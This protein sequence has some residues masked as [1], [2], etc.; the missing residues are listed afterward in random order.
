MNSRWFNISVF[1]LWLT[2][3][4]WL[5]IVKIMPS[6][7]VGDPPD[8]VATLSAQAEEETVGYEVHWEED[9][10]GH[11]LI[12]ADRMESGATLID[13]QVHFD[14]LPIRRIFPEALLELLGLNSTVP[15]EIELAARN[16]ALFQAGGGLQRFESTV[17]LDPT[18]SVVKIEGFVAGE[19]LILTI[20]SGGV[21]YET[22][23]PLPQRAMISDGLMPQT[24]MLGLSEGRRWTV[25]VYS[26]LR[27]RTS[28]M[29][30]MQAEVVGRDFITW[31][32]RVE[33]VWLVVYRGDPGSSL[34]RAGKEHAWLW[35]RD[36]GVVLQHRI[37][38]LDGSLTFLRMPEDQ[39]RDLEQS[40]GRQS[41]DFL[42]SDEVAPFIH[43]TSEWVSPD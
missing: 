29:E 14:R 41:R 27:P 3:M 35:V 25:E 7:M 10:I 39:S 42:N 6:L 28:P 20:R 15:D 2:T 11:A 24:R 1:A 13:G 26:P 43:T 34:A 8:Q 4:S 38:V 12:R 36:D 18:I 16:Q 19:I 5:V 22:R 30:I 33:N 23:R 37:S 17:S 32:G 9:R 21:T 40:I 31:N